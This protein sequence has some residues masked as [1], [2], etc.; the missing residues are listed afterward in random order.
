V[1]YQLIFKPT[2]YACALMADAT[3]TDDFR[4]KLAGLSVGEVIY[5][6]Y[7]L[8]EGDP[9]GNARLLASWFRRH[10]SCRHAMAMKRSISNTIWQGID[11]ASLGRPLF[12]TARFSNGP[13]SHSIP[14]SACDRSVG[15]EFILL[16]PDKSLESGREFANRLRE[17]IRQLSMS[18][19]GQSIGRVTVS[20]G[21]AALPLGYVREGCCDRV[22]AAI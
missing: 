15:E 19:N 21:V 3:V 10:Q 20:F 5:D 7:T 13:C 18:S 8:M 4:I 9:A 16:L 2:A 11:L 1:P 14:F 12:V 6:I 17:K 22:G